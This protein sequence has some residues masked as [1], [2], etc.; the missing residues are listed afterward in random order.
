[1]MGRTREGI[2]ALLAPGLGDKL[3]VADYVADRYRQALD[4]VPRLPGETGLERRMREICYLHLTR[5]VQILLDRKD[6]MSMAVGLE[7]RVPFCD[8]RLVQYVFNSPWRFKTFDGREKSLLRAATRDVLPESIVQRVKS[9]YPSTQDPTYHAALREEVT[10]LLVDE[11]APASQVFNAETVRGLAAMP[12]G[13]AQF[14]R[15][16]LEFV[17]N[18]NAWLERYRVRVDV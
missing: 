8:H 7:V 17:L 12:P 4:E 1:M 13:S 6:R 10:K 14:A 15:M 2:G 5:F 9:P 11:T 18:V 3:A 16:G